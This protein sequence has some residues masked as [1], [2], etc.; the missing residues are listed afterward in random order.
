MA[1]L[2]YEIERIDL[3]MAGGKQDQYSA[4]F[5]GF[6]FMEFHKEDRVIVNP[7][8]IKRRYI[9]ELESSFVL[10]YTGMSRKSAEII[11]SQ[12][13]N[14]NQKQSKSIEAMH[15]VKEQAQLMKEALLR[16]ELHKI[17]EILNFGWT[18]KKKMSD[19][20]SNDLIDTIYETAMAAGASGGK[21]SGAGGG[22]FM[23]F[24]CPG[25][26]RYNVLEALSQFDG[27][28][29]PVQFI[30]EGVVSWQNG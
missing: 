6:N 1:H 19:N 17:G 14:V 12:V 10:Y 8:R 20:I 21:V 15:N 25:S 4:T 9:H 5:G 23:F 2:A 7:L 29:Y 11:D 3:N 18:N 16:G 13:R 30:E 22:G 26:S 27:T 28:V 24:Y